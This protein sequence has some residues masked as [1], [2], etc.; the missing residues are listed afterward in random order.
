M[1][2]IMRE[3][4]IEA[5]RRLPRQPGFPP[6]S[7]WFWQEWALAGVVALIMGIVVGVIWAHNSADQCLVEDRQT[8]ACLLATMIN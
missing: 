7:G 2:D 4:E 1:R 3:M 8:L 6:G 5:A